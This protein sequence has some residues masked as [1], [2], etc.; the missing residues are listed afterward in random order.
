MGEVTGT[1]EGTAACSPPSSVCPT[2][3]ASPAAGQNPSFSFLA[4]Q[5]MK[6]LRP[7]QVLYKGCKRL[8]K[9]PGCGPGHGKSLTATPNSG[10]HSGGNPRVFQ[11]HGTNPQGSSPSPQAM[12]LLHWMGGL[13]PNSV[14]P[15]KSISSLYVSPVLSPKTS[16]GYFSTT[17]LSYVVN[18]PELGHLSAG[19]AAAP[20]LS[21]VKCPI[22]NKPSSFH[23][24]S[25]MLA[26][27]KKQCLWWECFQFQWSLGR[28]CLFFYI[29]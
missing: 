23:F 20:N 8:W 4:Q 9:W 1:W 3:L 10:L 12:L 28:K 5:E 13:C 22:S 21:P 15:R 14:K 25:T 7:I 26:L 29:F 24:H 16:G 18:P 2:S 6:A 27:L 17:G 19:F 11:G